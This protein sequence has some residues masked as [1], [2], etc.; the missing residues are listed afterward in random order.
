MS[1][2]RR[3]GFISTEERKRESLPTARVEKF[4][5]GERSLPLAWSKERAQSEKELWIS[6]I[7]K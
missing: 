6:V 7:R 3:V 5:M 4:A 2:R 1:S